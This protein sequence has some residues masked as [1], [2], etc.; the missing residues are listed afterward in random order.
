MKRPHLMLATVMGGMLLVVG[1][2]YFYL[3]NR[4]AA[5]HAA[6]EDLAACRTLAGRIADLRTRPALAGTQ[7]LGA[8]DLARRVERAAGV[9]HFAQE[10]I[11]RID[12][13]PARRV[14][15]TNYTQ[16]P[17]RVRLRRVNLEQAMTFL[18]TLG[19]EAGSPLRVEQV[20]FSS[21]PGEETG[22]RWTMESTLC[23]TVYSP[24]E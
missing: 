7:E 10:N 20:R 23:Y 17:T 2:S 9:A 4:R 12:P 6:G 8:E 22:D 16:V 11:E 5:A 24:R 3:D 19:S 13:E 15:E 18:H 14:G 21:P 1:W